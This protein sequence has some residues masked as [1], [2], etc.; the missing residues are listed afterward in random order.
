[1]NILA[2]AIVGAILGAA[3]GFL[4]G[5]GVAARTAA[6]TIA[7]LVRQ[8]GHRDRALAARN[9]QWAGLDQLLTRWDSLHPAPGSYQLAADE[10]RAYITGCEHD[11]GLA[12]IR[13]RT[14]KE[15]S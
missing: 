8:V 14:S 7:A 4:A 6:E 2:A 3:V 9:K 5:L 12:A 1:M 11:E 13:E 10:L 15:P